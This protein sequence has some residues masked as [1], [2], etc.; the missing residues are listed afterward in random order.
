MKFQT[1]LLV[2]YVVFLLS[3]KH[4][5]NSGLSKVNDTICKYDTLNVMSR[6]E[7][8]NYIRNRK[9]WIRRYNQAYNAIKSNDFDPDFFINI[10]SGAN[11][12]YVSY[13]ITGMIHNETIINEAVVLFYLKFY[14]AFLN[15]EKYCYKIISDVGE[16]SFTPIFYTI[17]CK[18]SNHPPEKGM[19]ANTVYNWVLKQPEYLKNK[20]IKSEIE[21]IEKLEQSK[22]EK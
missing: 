13:F 12:V 16:N 15:E 11:S 21:R 9:N 20:D 22:G 17:F 14:Y 8:D 2:F 10:R 3:C 19:L 7:N 18:I 1:V 6:F 5:D 4:Q